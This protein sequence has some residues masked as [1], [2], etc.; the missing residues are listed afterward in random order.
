LRQG[1][2]LLPGVGVCPGQRHLRPARKERRPF[3]ATV[4]QS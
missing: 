3:R 2:Q 4:A 1:S